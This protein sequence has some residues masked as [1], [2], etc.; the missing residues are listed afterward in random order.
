M[1]DQYLQLLSSLQS[2]TTTT[3]K[4]A[5]AQYDQLRTTQPDNAVAFTVQIVCT[6]AYPLDQR[7]FACVLFRRM[8]RPGACFTKITPSKQH[9]VRQS[10]LN[11]LTADE[12]TSPKTLRRTVV[13]CVASLAVTGDAQLNDLNKSWPEL[14][15]T[16]SGL[17]GNTNTQ[18]YHR[19]SGHDLLRRL[20]E[21]KPDA[22]LGHATIIQ[23]VMA[24]GLSDSSP[25]VRLAALQGCSQFL[26]LLESEDEQR[27]FLP[28]VPAL[29]NTLSG[30]L[31]G[32]NELSARDALEA[33]VSVAEAQPTF[34][35]THLPLVWN[36]MCTVSSHQALE[37]ETRTMAL[38]LLLAICEQAGGMVRKHTALIE[39]LVQVV[40][41][42][43]CQVDDVD[44]S[45]W[46]TAE[47]NEAT[48][49]DSLDEDE[50]SNI[51][52]QA[53][54]R[55]ATSLGGKIMT[56]ILLPL[57]TAFLNDSTDWRKRRA[58]LESLALCAAGCGKSF[59]AMLQQLVT[60]SVQYCKDAHVRVR[61]S[62]LHCLGQFASDFQPVM[63]RKY[64][65]IVLPVLGASLTSLNEGCERLQRLA[66]S[67]LVNMCN[68]HC[69]KTTFMTYTKPLL[70]GLFALLGHSGAKTQADVFTAVAAIASVIG[71]QFVPYYDI[72]M[73]LA[74]NVLTQ[75]QQQQVI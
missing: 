62:S 55:L 43:L 11:L 48:Y 29:M 38:E 4:A 51:A 75:Q 46:S 30:L 9:H 31:S 41:T 18:T 42:V 24:T 16:V 67:A 8:V 27:L 19:E 2:T 17:A 12:S 59:E 36:A 50:I 45:V 68:E 37:P 23:G 25:D 66:V 44:V 6:P 53:L 20:I 1:A 58:G 52:E 54:D 40:M 73:P 49:G 56:P 26:T 72:F 39:Q 5:E 64:Q 74:L 35:R 7:V 70:E 3:R 57:V 10:I 34:W 61:Y 15:Q 22:L 13:H 14:L 21:A 65:N 47:E 71:K 28:L 33:L 60:T 63:Q 69:D 32:G